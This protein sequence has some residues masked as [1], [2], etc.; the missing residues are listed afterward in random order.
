MNGQGISTACLGVATLDETLREVDLD[1]EKLTPEF[2]GRL[3]ERMQYPWRQALG[4]DFEF[5]ATVGDRPAPT[6]DSAQ[7][8]AFRQALGELSTVDLEVAEAAALSGHRFDPGLVRTPEIMAKVADW[9]AEGRR[10]PYTDPT[11]PPPGPD[12]PR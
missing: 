3:A 5:D 12:D 11:V 9:I 4:Y 7:Q 6:P 1:F 10:S 2:P 8:A